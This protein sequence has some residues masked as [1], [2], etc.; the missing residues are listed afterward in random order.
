V[1]G[2]VGA[3]WAADSA[4]DLG[5]ESDTIISKGVGFRYL[6]AKKLGLWSGIDVAAGPEDTVFY[7]QAGSAW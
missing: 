6:I 3:G 2:F 7:I 1:L 4:S 5:G